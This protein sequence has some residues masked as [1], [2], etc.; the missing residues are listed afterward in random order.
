MATKSTTVRTNTKAKTA[1]LDARISNRL[2]VLVK[3]AAE[4][5][6]TTMT[7]FVVHALEAAA[8]ETIEHSNQ[9]LLAVQDQEAFARALIP[10]KNRTLRLSVLSPKQTNCSYLEVG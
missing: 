1:G 8:T 9:V 7:D 5:Q 10:P 4:I 3:R 6:G 2:Q